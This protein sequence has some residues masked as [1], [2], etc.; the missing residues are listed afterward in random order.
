MINEVEAVARGTKIKEEEPFVILTIPV[1][2]NGK[3]EFVQTK[4]YHVSALEEPQKLEKN[5]EEAANQKIETYL[6]NK[7]KIEYGKTRITAIFMTE[8]GVS[9]QL[10]ATIDAYDEENNV[11]LL[12]GFKFDKYIKP[13]YCYF[14]K[15]D[16]I[17]RQHKFNFRKKILHKKY[18]FSLSMT[19]NEMTKKLNAKKIWNCGLI[20]YVWKNEKI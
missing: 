2:N 3:T 7:Y 18:G 10:N 13:D 5:V 12:L 20:K 6:K 17:K 4:Y 9:K 19:E 14:I 11:Y 15:K 16:G 8:K 1:D